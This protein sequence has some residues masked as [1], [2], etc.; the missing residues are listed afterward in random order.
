[1]SEEVG[2]LIDRL[3]VEADMLNPA[4][5]PKFAFKLAHRLDWLFSQYAVV[6][7]EA[8]RQ[9]IEIERLNGMLLECMSVRQRDLRREDG[10]RR[11]LF[12]S[13][14]RLAKALG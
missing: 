3:L 9:R 8:R 10:M 12:F 13:I 2:K 5:M 14:Q 7:E 4:F 1:M 11:D 6:P